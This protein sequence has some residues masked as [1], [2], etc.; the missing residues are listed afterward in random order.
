MRP[1]FFFA[2]SPPRI[3]SLVARTGRPPLG[4]PQGITYPI[5]PLQPNGLYG[6]NVMRPFFFALPPPDRSSPARAVRP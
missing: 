2:L 3:G 1:Y 6:R 4:L 5:L